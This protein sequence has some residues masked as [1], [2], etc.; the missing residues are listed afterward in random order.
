M[1]YKETPIGKIPEDWGVVRLG[2]SG[3]AEIRG[4]K[5]VN[6]VEK[7]AFIPMEF[8]PDSSIYTK[9]EIRNLNEVKSSTY[10]EAGDLLLAKITPSL[11]NGK[12]GI[13]PENIPNGFALATTEVFPIVCKGIDRLFLFYILKHPR[14]RKVLEYSMRG[15]TGRQRV[16]KEA[17]ENLL[18]PYPPLEEQRKIAEIL[19]TVDDA[20][21]KVDEAIAK[22]ERLKKG[23]M[24]ELL[25]KGI[26]HTE[27]KDTEIGRIPKEWEVVRLEDVTIDIQQGFASG[28]RDENGVIQL[29]MNN[30][31]T[32]GRIVLDSYIKVPIP[33]NI[34]RYLLKP[35]DI[36]FNNTNSV[37][38]I[39]KTAIFRGECNFCTY[40]NHITRIRVDKTKVVPE[41]ILYNFIKK[42]QGKYFRQICVRHV[43]QAGIRSEDLRNTKLPLPPLEEQRKIAEILSTVDKKLELERKRKEK[44]ERIKKGLMNDLL[45][46]KRRVKVS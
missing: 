19:S 5:S 9:Y 23:L 26:G 11:E 17:V 16:P 24:Q 15:T 8:I 42:W 18:I 7:I 34:D 39:G 38:L 2:D 4:N 21:Q 44:L 33:D 10:C 25:T 29:R 41:W 20:I 28:K 30:I 35:E 6:N 13:V 31:T 45:T 40:S 27:F 37:D 3:V 43:G 22:T 36:L 1:R 14:F 32:D 12:Q 46:G